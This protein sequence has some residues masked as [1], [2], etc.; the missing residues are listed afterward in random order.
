MWILVH[1]SENYVAN[2]HL[3]PTL[4]MDLIVPPLAQIMPVETAGRLF[5]ALTMALPV[6]AHGGAASRAARPRRAMAAV[7][8][9]L[10]L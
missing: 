1:G 2:W 8:I 10:R 4:A 7:L 3:L 6:I 5:I 9:A